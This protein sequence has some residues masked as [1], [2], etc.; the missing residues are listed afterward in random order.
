MLNR[1]QLEVTQRAYAVAEVYLEDV[2]KTIRPFDGLKVA[3]VDGWLTKAFQAEIIKLLPAYPHSSDIKVRLSKSYTALTLEV[4]V[5]KSVESGY[6]YEGQAHF[7]VGRIDEYTKLLEVKNLLEQ[8]L[9]SC[10]KVSLES[11]EDLLEAD[12]EVK[13]LETLLREAQSKIPPYMK[14]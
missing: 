11:Y 9:A 7:Y 10:K 6:S 8:Q 14:R 5:H 12:S 13:K 2:Y 1:T 4:S 3:K